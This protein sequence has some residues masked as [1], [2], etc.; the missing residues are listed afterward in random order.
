MLLRETRSV[1]TG[2]HHGMPRA[3]A[4][5]VALDGAHPLAI[6]HLQQGRSSQH[7]SHRTR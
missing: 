6:P 7:C 4:A 1:S 5:T 3:S 2:N